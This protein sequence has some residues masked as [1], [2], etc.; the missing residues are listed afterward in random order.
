MHFAFIPYGKKEAVD[1]LIRDM[2]AQKH[3]LILMKGEEINSVWIEG[4]VRILPFGI[5]EY[6]FP[7]E[8]LDKVLA[9]LIKEEN[10]YKIPKIAFKFIRKFLKLEKIPEFKKNEF[11]LWM[12]ENVNI[13]PLGIRK[14]EMLTEKSE[15]MKGWIHEAI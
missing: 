15:A 11:Y 10:R 7:R 3:R 5:Y 9:T 14:D 6:V 4:Q 13:I 12:K 1:T 2:S 8:D